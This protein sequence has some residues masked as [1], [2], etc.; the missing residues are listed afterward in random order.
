MKDHTN[1][2]AVKVDIS[3]RESIRAAI[4]KSAEHF[5]KQISILINNAGIAQEKPFLEITD[6]DWDRML[7]TN[8]RGAFFFSQEVIPG[9]DKQNFGRI[10]N[11][12]SI[13][14]QWDGINQVH[15]A[16]SKAGL[17]NLTRSLAKLFSKDGINT[18]AVAIGLTLTDMASPEI[19]SQAGREKIKSIPIERIANVEEIANVVSFLCSEEASYITGQTINVNGGMYFG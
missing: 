12:T 9:M 5:G 18:N 19:K 16:A 13:G 8:L 2:F 3:E 10:V 4:K 14:G 15:Y 1:A 11:I 6:E 17:I 7:V